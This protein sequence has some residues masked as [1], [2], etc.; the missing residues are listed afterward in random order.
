MSSPPPLTKS[1]LVNLYKKR[2]WS[3]G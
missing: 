1:K 3:K 2:K